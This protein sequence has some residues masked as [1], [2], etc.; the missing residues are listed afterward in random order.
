MVWPLPM[1]GLSKS[2]M[3]P[4]FCQDHLNALAGGDEIAEEDIFTARVD[5]EEVRE[6]KGGDSPALSSLSS[7][8]VVEGADDE[9]DVPVVPVPAEGSNPEGLPVAAVENDSDQ[10]SSASE[11]EGILP[12][13]MCLGPSA[14]L[15]KAKRPIS[16]S[17]ARQLDGLHLGAEI[18]PLFKRPQEWEG[19]DPIASMTICQRC[20]GR[21]LRGLY[22]SYQ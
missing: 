7:P 3:W 18:A 2:W 12:P 21:M 5:K 9:Q 4:E 13:G 10:S 1:E 8:R 19:L 17:I 6:D 14:G 20:P 15:C 11:L 16:F 22:S